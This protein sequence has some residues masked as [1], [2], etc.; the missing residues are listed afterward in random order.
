M[1]LIGSLIAWA[2]WIYLAVLTVRAVLSLIPVLVRDWQPSGV[3]LVVAEFV[4]TLTDPPL[5]FL[6]KFIPSVRLGDFSVDLSF[7]VLWI[8][9]SLLGRWLPY[10]FFMS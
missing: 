4:Y 9:L 6:R 3:V 10:L 2:I 5:R 1:A 7:I 8:G